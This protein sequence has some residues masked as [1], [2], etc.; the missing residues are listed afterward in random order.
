MIPLPSRTEESD[1]IQRGLRSPRGQLFEAVE[2][3][4][5]LLVRNLEMLRR[6]SDFY[7]EVDRA[8]YLLLR[9]LEQVGPS[10]IRTLASVLGLDPST[11]GRQVNAAEAAGLVGRVPDDTDRRRNVVTLTPAGLDAMRA[12]QHRRQDGTAQMLHEWSDPDLRS[13]LEMFTRYNEAIARRYIQPGHASDVDP[14][15]GPAT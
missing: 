13:L 9:T 10:D 6:R 7:A 12:V 2:L 8:G 4:S 15:Q 11:T 14:S 5:A 3:Q 1:T